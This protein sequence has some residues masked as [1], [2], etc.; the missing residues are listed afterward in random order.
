[1]FSVQDEVEKHSTPLL[2]LT[3]EHNDRPYILLFFANAQI[4]EDPAANLL[5]A[6]AQFASLLSVQMHLQIV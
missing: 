1:M 5:Q 6:D 2:P 3:R 4:E